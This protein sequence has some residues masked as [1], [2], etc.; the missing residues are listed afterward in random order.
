MRASLQ[1]LSGRILR[2]SSRPEVPPLKKSIW[3]T[4]QADIKLFSINWRSILL[5]NGSELVLNCSVEKIVPDVSG[6]IRVFYHN[7][8]EHFD[9]I[10]FTAPLSILEKIASPDLFKISKNNQTVDYLG[11][12][13]MVIISDNSFN[14]LLCIKYCR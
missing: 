12:I 9:K 14:T 8:E 3:A 5:Q 1:Y 13:C 4:F 2:G 7:K 10:I 6:G 11:V